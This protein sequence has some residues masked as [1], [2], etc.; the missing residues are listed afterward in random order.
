MTR[1]TKISKHTKIVVGIAVVV[2]VVAISS[3]FF[4]GTNNGYKTISVKRDTLVRTVAVTGEVI[5]VDEVTL[6]FTVG[7]RVSYLPITDG[8]VITRGTVLASLDSSEVQANIRQATAD[9]AVAEAELSALVGSSN[10]QGKIAAT[11]QQAL[12]SIKKALSVADTQVLTNVDALFDD[13]KTGR[14]E[15]TRAVKDFF[16]RQAIGQERVTIGKLL[17]AWHTD[18]ASLQASAVTEKTLATTYQNLSSVQTYLTNISNALSDAESTNQITEAQIST[19]R[20][21][22]AN[23]RA[24]VDV[25]LT[26]ISSV[27]DT[28]RAVIAENPVQNAKVSSSVASIDRYNALLQNYTLA[29]PFDGVVADVYVTQGEVVAMNQDIVSLVSEGT[30]ELEVYIPE[31]NIAQVDIGDMATVKLD[32]FGDS[33]T[34]GAVV[35]FIDTRATP[36]NGIVTYKTKLVFTDTPSD[37]RPGMTATI[38]I[39]AVKTPDVLMIPQAVTRVVDGVT[40]V[41]VL[42]ENKKVTRPV[43]LGMTDTRGGVTVESGLTEGDLVIIGE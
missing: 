18:I 9:K 26:D 22:V 39:D 41:D 8:Q 30:V 33:R 21:T 36:K 27:Q 19:Y 43:V 35:T 17:E 20:T 3:F 2:V 42:V 31:V 16:A 32:A 1:K 11:K 24:A 37:V 14:P 40:V 5:P 6:A 4:F 7:G 34:L 23:A 13:P 15:I 28:L 10:T 29:A 25:V 12:T 38:S